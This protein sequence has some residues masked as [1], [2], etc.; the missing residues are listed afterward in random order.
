[1]AARK[2]DR[3]EVVHDV[4]KTVQDKDGIGPTRLLY[5]SNLSP[6]MHREY[7]SGLLA[8]GLLEER[9]R[10]GRKTYHLTDKGCDFLGRYES[11]SRFV[12]E[13]GL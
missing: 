13:L 9:E 10:K 12:D 11:F 1:M 6:Q 7:L 2:R 3:L 4:L 8:Q 5:A